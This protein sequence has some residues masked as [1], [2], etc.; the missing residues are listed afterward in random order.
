MLNQ[1]C[2]S[3]A[4]KKIQFG[5]YNFVGQRYGAVC[6]ISCSMEPEEEIADV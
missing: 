5:R 1:F 4:Y 6:T 3:E 2:Q